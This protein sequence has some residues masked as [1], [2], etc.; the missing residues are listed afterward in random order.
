MTPN[1]NQDRGVREVKSAARTVDVLEV[2]S[3][4]S[5]RPMR[6]QELAEQLGVP[7]SSMYALLQ[8][9]VERGWVR[10]DETGS[11]YRIG[12]RALL[13]GTSYLD[14]EPRLVTVRPILESIAE[15][16]GET[17]HF[18]RLD[19]ADIVYLFTRESRHYL[20]RFSR[21]GR[22][23][24]AHCTAMGK[25]LL[26]EQPLRYVES[27]L[28]RPIPGLTPKSITD[29]TALLSEL[30][31]TREAGYATDHEENVQG[32]VCFGLALRYDR[33]PIDAFSCSIPL[34]RL[35]PEKEKEII[36]TLQHA[37]REIELSRYAD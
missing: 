20:R 35:T 19:R 3:S 4:Q 32:L 21:V 26:A 29:M 12:I 23:L 30:D 31:K 25:A 10:S 16:L 11:L 5:G 2:L 33:P 27:Q 37:R 14:S 13:A 34:S 8:T 18:G 28:P 36:E 15:E 9:L 24:P 7:R 6:L 17:I 22:R 1:G